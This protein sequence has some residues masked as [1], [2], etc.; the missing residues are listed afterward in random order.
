MTDTV[1]LISQFS[2]T[3]KTDFFLFIPEQI[4]FVNLFFGGSFHLYD[5]GTTPAHRV[6]DFSPLPQHLQG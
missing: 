6:C 4:L 1:H 3:S 2:R 5:L